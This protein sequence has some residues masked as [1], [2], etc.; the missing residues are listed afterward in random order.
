ML[1]LHLS[2][3]GAATLAVVA[4]GIIALVCVGCYVLA[5]KAGEDGS[6]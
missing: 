1:L 3:V 6:L 2:I 5:R 4:L